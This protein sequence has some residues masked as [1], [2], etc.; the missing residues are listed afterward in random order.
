MVA[1]IR[2]QSHSADLEPADSD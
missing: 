1:L 2:V